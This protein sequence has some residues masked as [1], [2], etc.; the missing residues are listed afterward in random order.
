LIVPLAALGTWTQT[1]STDPKLVSAAAH[2]AVSGHGTES[3]CS[4]SVN[5]ARDARST[6]VPRRAVCIPDACPLSSDDWTWCRP[7]RRKAWRHPGS[8]C[9][10]TSWS[11]TMLGSRPAKAL[12][13]STRRDRRRAT[14]QVISRR[15]LTQARVVSL[16][17][18]RDLP[19]PGVDARSCTIA[20]IRGPFRP[21]EKPV[22]HRS[23]PGG[24][25]WSFWN[26]PRRARSHASSVQARLTR[27]LAPPRYGRCIS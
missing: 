7:I 24:F 10:V 16:T 11:A 21:I 9:R 5:G 15:R 19:Q 2:S 1:I 22:G 12:A 8:V 23:G 26:L 13:C 3:G 25:G 14:F 18:I 4:I 17:P 27:G 20:R 6:P